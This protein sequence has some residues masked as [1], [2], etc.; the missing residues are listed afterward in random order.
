MTLLIL[1]ALKPDNRVAQQLD[2]TRGSPHSIEPEEARMSTSI[3]LSGNQPLPLH[4]GHF[5]DFR[6][7]EHSTGFVIEPVLM[8]PL[9]PQS[10]QVPVLWHALQDMCC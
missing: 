6:H 8:R 7:L 2:T 1:P 5:P 9:P 10:W 4:L 3:P